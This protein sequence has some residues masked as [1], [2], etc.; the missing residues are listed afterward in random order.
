MTVT[1]IS[2]QTGH[3]YA[4]AN[5]MNYEIYC[6]GVKL[7]YCVTANADEGWAEILLTD[8]NGNIRSGEYSSIMQRVFG[9]IEIKK[10]K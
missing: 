3:P 1:K 4:I 9:K 7:Q 2:A 10:I 5:T 6:D 8:K